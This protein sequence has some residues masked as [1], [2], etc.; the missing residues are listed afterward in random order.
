LVARAGY[1]QRLNQLG[2]Y[3]GTTVALEL[4]YRFCGHRAT[5]CPSVD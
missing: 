5:R 1:S 2:Q 3:E 4:R